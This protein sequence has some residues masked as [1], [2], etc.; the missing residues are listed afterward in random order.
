MTLVLVTI[1]AIYAV[2]ALERREE[3]RRIPSIVNISYDLFAAI[4]DIRLERGATNRALAGPEISGGDAEDEI[5][6]LRAQSGNSLDSALTKLAAIRMEGIEPEIKEIEK[7]REAFAAL[8]RDIDQALRQP[9]EQRSENL[10]SLWLAATAKLVGAIDALSS[11]L[12]SELSQSDVFVAE[13]IRIKQIVWPV[14]SDSGDDRLL[15]R[16]AMTSNASLSAAQLRKLDDLSGRIESAWHLVQDAGRRPTTPARLKDAIDAADKIYFTDFRALRNRV[17]D[18]LAAGRPVDVDMGEWLR[19]TAAGRANVYAVAETAFDLASLHAVEQSAAAEKEFYA[20]LA[21]M[22]LF[23][24]VGAL[25][26]FYVIRG[27]V[28]PITQIAETMKVVADG[29][30]TCAIPFENRTDE[31]GLLSRGLRIF[32][33]NA[34]EKQQLY[35]AKVGAETANRTKSEFLANMSHELRTP[36]NAVI[37]FSEVIKRSMFG[38]LN[39][40][41]REYASDIFNSGTHLLKLINEILDLSK[42]EA[43]QAELYEEDVD[44]AAIIES[45]VHLME[46]Q[47]QSAKVRLL[48]KVANDVPLIRADDRRMRQIL[49]NLLSNAVKFTPEGGQVRVSTSLANGGVTIEVKDT[50]I[51]MA[52]DQIP[53]A[54]EPFRQ[55]DSK[56]SRKYHGTG[57]GLPLTKHLVELHGGSLT[58]ESRPN[59]GTTVTCLLPGERIVE[60]SAR[61][62]G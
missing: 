6:K 15:V 57:L 45:C 2:H 18:E 47:A 36:L 5:A 56:I 42:L 61:L 26:G 10:N 59:I 51:G 49:I 38:P 29:N 4:Q 52:P 53:K 32:Q 31:I 21:L 54:L 23:F 28:S 43:K 22:L 17:V 41:Y 39:E 11:Q 34:I 58:I 62:A 7:S 50:G 30:L 24:G 46:A 27:V 20:A 55:I 1:F 25:T 8:R 3:A 9:K 14:R 37:G 48:S 35:L 16:E 44:L 60:A 33:D 40:R 13:M 12:E 19:L